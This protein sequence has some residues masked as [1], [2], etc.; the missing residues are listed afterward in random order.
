MF[1][2]TRQ[3]KSVIIFLIITFTIG[4]GIITIRKLSYRNTIE[5]FKSRY[6]EMDKNFSEISKNDSLFNIQKEKDANQTINLKININTADEDE[7]IKLPG[8]GPV[9]SKRIVSYRK[10]VG[11][12]KKTSEIINVKGIGKKK[13][14]KILPFIYID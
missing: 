2:F 10:S 6:S 12:F 11:K 13:F 4:T 8:I 7:L 1:G 9:L 3:E 14:E 5:Q